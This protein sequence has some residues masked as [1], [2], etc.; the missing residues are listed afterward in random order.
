MAF[1]TPSNWYRSTW[2]AFFDRVASGPDIGDAWKV[3]L[4]TNSVDGGSVNN[5]DT[6]TGYDYAASPW[7]SN[8]VANGSGYTTGGAAVTLATSVGSTAGGTAFKL[9]AVPPATAWT[10][11]TFTARGCL[12]YDST[13][14]I[15]FALAAINFGSDQ[16]PSAGTLTINWNS[17]TPFTIVTMT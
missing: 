8:E 1:P 5:F 12:V 16:S 4:F 7:T 10:T 15:K 11:S 14:T 17:G 6:T 13:N 2:A 9:N 3:A